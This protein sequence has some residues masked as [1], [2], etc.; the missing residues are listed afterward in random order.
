MLRPVLTI[1][2]ALAA[3]RGCNSTRIAVLAGAGVIVLVAGVSA[4]LIA[5]A[6]AAFF[7]I[8]PALG[9]VWAAALAAVAVS[10]ISA[11]GIGLLAW[12]ARREGRGSH[13]ATLDA[14]KADGA[15]LLGTV[16]SAFLTGLVAGLDRHEA[17]A[18]GDRS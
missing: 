12:I 6:A 13:A 14:G 15:L 1:F 5:L 11:L 8:E 17:A 4:M 16:A 9:A 2:H 18:K 7:A 10:A 3:S